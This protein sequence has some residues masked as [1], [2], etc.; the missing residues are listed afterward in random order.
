MS[1]HRVFSYSPIDKSSRSSNSS[2]NSWRACRISSTTALWL[3]FIARFSLLLP[4]RLAGRCRRCCCSSLYVTPIEHD[5]WRARHC[6]S[7]LGSF[8][9]CYSRS[10]GLRVARKTCDDSICFD[11]H[12]SSNQRKKATKP[13][14][15]RK[16]LK[17]SLKSSH[18]NLSFFKIRKKRRKRPQEEKRLTAL[19]QSTSKSFLHSNLILWKRKEKKR[20]KEEEEEALFVVFAC[21]TCVCPVQALLQ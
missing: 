16:A 4:F 2:W 10:K 21:L 18:S 6:F 13:T 20:K 11:A 9:I 5:W 19:Q 1:L 12:L 3:E 15:K 17:C 8:L 14:D 7:I